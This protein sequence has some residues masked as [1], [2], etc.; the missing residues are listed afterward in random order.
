LEYRILEFYL[1]SISLLL[2]VFLSFT[3]N[4]LIYDWKKSRPIS[5][6]EKSRGAIIKGEPQD[7]IA[8]LLKAKPM[9]SHLE[10]PIGPI[11]WSKSQQALIPPENL[12]QQAISSINNQNW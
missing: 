6:D 12:G 5:L 10:N 2:S 7:A 4:T 3:L 11:V 8:E 9:K 1:C